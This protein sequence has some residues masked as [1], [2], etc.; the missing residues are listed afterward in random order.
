MDADRV[1]LLVDEGEAPAVDRGWIGERHETAV[2]AG[3]QGGQLA[4]QAFDEPFRVAAGDSQHQVGA[5]EGGAVERLDVVHG[6]GLETAHRAGR[7]VAVRVAGEQHLLHRLETQELVVAGPQVVGEIGLE[8]IAVPAQVAV[9]E[10]R[11]QHRLGQQRGVLGELVAVHLARDHGDLAI[12]VDVDRGGHRVQQIDELGIGVLGG[13]AV[14]DHPGGERRQPF[15][16]LGIVDR[17]GPEQQADRHQRRAGAGKGDG[18]DGLHGGLLG[19]L[20]GSAAGGQ[21]DQGCGDEDLAG[22]PP[23]S[24]C[25]A[26]CSSAAAG[27]AGV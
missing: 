24:C 25:A 6:D 12:G 7:S 5:G 3:G 2:A 14:G 9:G 17:A 16:A 4:G 21:G 13:G 22:H 15:L 11:L 8:L 19:R 23:T 27:S 20:A 10:G 26:G 18:L 1:G